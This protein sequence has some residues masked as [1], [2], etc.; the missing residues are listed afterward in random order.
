MD[1][2]KEHTSVNVTSA[3]AALNQ[4]RKRGIPDSGLACDQK[5]N[6]C[7]TTS[8]ASIWRSEG[9]TVCVKLEVCIGERT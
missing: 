9:L 8:L 3:D 7:S 1:R 4:A 5:L 6:Y 2:F